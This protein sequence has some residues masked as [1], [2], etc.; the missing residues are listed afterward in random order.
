MP[1]PMSYLK[2]AEDLAAR[3]KSGEYQ[4]GQQLPSYNELATLYSVHFSTIT[5][6]IGVL[7]LQGLVIG[8]PGRGVFVPED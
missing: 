1:L 6:A 2:I 8:V 7:R 5:R 4:P 3:I